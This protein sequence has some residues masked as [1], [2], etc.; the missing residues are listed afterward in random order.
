MNRLMELAKTKN[1]N[2]E[3]SQS[4]KE[5]QKYILIRIVQRVPREQMTNEWKW[6]SH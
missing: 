6:V 3:L 2:N 4:Q 5:R 1:L